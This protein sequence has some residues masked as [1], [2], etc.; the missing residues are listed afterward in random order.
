MSVK[1]YVRDWLFPAE[2]AEETYQL[3][4][5]EHLFY[6]V[7]CTTSAP[8]P[9]MDDFESDTRYWG[10]KLYEWEQQKDVVYKRYNISAATVVTKGDS[11]KRQVAMFSEGG[12]KF[13]IADWEICVDQTGLK[14]LTCRFQDC[15]D[16]LHQKVLKLKT[17][18]LNMTNAQ[19]EKQ[20]AVRLR[21]RYYTEIEFVLS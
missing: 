10:D 6:H 19:W 20:K 5:K 14:K 13:P 7:Y 11:G 8:H 18:K 4:S 3:S 2:D 17:S 1:T 15:R 9:S 21:G 12:K 16:M